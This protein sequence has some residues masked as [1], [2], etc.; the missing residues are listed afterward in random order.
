MRRADSL[1][2]DRNGVGRLVTSFYAKW[3]ETVLR[4]G[5][6]AWK[7]MQDARVDGSTYGA[8]KTL[9]TRC[10]VGMNSSR[11]CICVLAVEYTAVVVNVEQ[12][13]NIRKING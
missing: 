8:P 2:G 9:Q 4:S 7:V 11:G 3:V 13:N 10:A 6:D 1:S 5:L 12:V